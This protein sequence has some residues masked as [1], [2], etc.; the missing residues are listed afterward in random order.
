M[1]TQWVDGIIT[2]KLPDWN[3]YPE[4]YKLVQTIYTGTQKHVRNIKAL[5]IDFV[6]QSFW[7]ENYSCKTITNKFFIVRKPQIMS[8]R[9]CLL[10]KIKKYIDTEFNTA[11]TWLSGTEI[12]FRNFDWSRNQKHNI[13]ARC[14]FQMRMISKSI[15]KETSEFLFCK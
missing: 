4:L 6:L 3:Q 1:Y 14:V 10:S 2:A 9:N 15:S 11:Y 7:W 8:N 12:N 13:K 5:H